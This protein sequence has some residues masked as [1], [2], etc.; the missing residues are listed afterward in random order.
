MASAHPINAYPSAVKKGHRRLSSL[1]PAVVILIA[2]ATSIPEVAD[3]DDDYVNCLINTA[4]KIM[5]TQIV[6]DPAKA[7]DEASKRCEPPPRMT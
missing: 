5:R 1:R 3:Q 4:V 2:L 7:L 6:R